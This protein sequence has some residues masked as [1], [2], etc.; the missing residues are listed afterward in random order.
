MT[1]RA[2]D[3]SAKTTFLTGHICWQDR[4]NKERGARNKAWAPWHRESGR[5]V[6]GK[7]VPRSILFTR[8]THWHR[9]NNMPGPGTASASA[10]L[11]PDNQPAVVGKTAESDWRERSRMGLQGTKSMPSL[12]ARRGEV[13]ASDHRYMLNLRNAELAA[14]QWHKPIQPSVFATLR[15]EH[16][17]E[18]RRSW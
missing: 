4:L 14:R 2:L 12:P 1:T 5:P 9:W 6:P 10:V 8:P 16:S 13:D 15:S 17:N 3:Q 11:D 7:D 18:D